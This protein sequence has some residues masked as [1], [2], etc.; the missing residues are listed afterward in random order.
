MQP[1]AEVRASPPAP[2]VGWT[3]SIHTSLPA[4]TESR[5]E[6]RNP[7]MQGAQ[8]P[9]RKMSP[10]FQLIVLVIFCGVSRRHHPARHV[11]SKHPG[12]SCMETTSHLDA[13]ALIALVLAHAPLICT[14]T[15]AIPPNP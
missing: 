7:Q 1:G 14:V 5:E 10:F 15:L 2:S 4:N 12:G 3:I 11:T 8:T 13:L 9:L 6:V